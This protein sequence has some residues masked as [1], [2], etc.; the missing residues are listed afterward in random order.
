[1]KNFTNIKIGYT[2]GVYGCTGE[3]FLVIYTSEKGLKSVCYKGMYGVEER[4][5]KVLK[6]AG[7]QENYTA[8]TYGKLVRNDLWKGILS[9]NLAI[10]ELEGRLSDE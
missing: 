10:K 3:Y 5:C 7:Y 8:S 6:D 2:S 4:V 1:M 9:E